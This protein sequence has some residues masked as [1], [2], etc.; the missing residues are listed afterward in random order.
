MDPKTE[1]TM[2]LSAAEHTDMEQKN[3][4]KTKGGWVECVIEINGQQLVIAYP[5]EE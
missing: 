5:E 1:A 2:R 4:S 3:T